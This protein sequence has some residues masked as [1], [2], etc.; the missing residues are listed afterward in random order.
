[1]GWF[2]QRPQRRRIAALL[3]SA[4]TWSIV[5]CGVAYT[6]APP[7]APPYMSAPVEPLPVKVPPPPPVLRKTPAPAEP[8]V[9]IPEGEPLPTE[10]PP[11]RQPTRD[12]VIQTDQLGH[13]KRQ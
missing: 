2:P 5:G 4:A 9:T 6:Q 11:S 8:I 1:M 3:Q 12:P 10:P 7:V 13:G